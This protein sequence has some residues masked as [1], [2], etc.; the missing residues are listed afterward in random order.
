MFHRG[1]Q[2]NT[3]RTSVV[4][5]ELVHEVVTV[6]DERIDDSLPCTRYSICPNPANQ[7]VLQND[8]KT[9]DFSVQFEF[10]S[11]VILFNIHTMYT[12][13][14]RASRL[15]LFHMTSYIVKWWSTMREPRLKRSY[16]DRFDVI[17]LKKNYTAQ[18]Y[19][20]QN[21][22]SMLRVCFVTYSFI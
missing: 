12:Q 8:L 14:Y 20:K 11:F 1:F 7:N 10:I 13:Q 19:F 5:T 6:R 3:R 16:R 15:I 21:I 2:K 18:Y 17:L 4:Q 22:M 9:D